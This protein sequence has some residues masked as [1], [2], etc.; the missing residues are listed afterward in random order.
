MN[1][2]LSLQ[3]VENVDG[4]IRHT[5]TG[6]RIQFYN[7]ADQQCDADKQN[8]LENCIGSNHHQSIHLAVHPRRAMC[9]CRHQARLRTFDLLI[10]DVMMAV[11]LQV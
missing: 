3:I 6:R 8:D 4:P 5:D 1:M 11:F 10:M 2:A 7:Q 9:L